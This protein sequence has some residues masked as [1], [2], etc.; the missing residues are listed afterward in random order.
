MKADNN[1]I[2]KNGSGCSDPTAFA[3]I[4]KVTRDGKLK[5]R[6]RQHDI[7]DAMHIINRF[8][9]IID[10]KLEGRITLIDKQTGRRYE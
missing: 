5:A 4:A 7:D 8:L 10:F 2:G 1:N 3:A 6:N 9:D